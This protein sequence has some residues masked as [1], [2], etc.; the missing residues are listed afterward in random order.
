MSRL[1]QAVIQPKVG[2]DRLTLS[3]IQAANLDW[4]R[5]VCEKA[6]HQLLL[7]F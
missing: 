4:I 7:N 3:D 1:S 5:E 2:P 6:G